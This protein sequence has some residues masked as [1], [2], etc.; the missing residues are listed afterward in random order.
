MI[1]ILNSNSLLNFGINARITVAAD[2][3]SLENGERLLQL[4]VGHGLFLP[5]AMN[6][7]LFVRPSHQVWGHCLGNA[8]GDATPIF[9]IKVTGDGS[10][11]GIVF[12]RSEVLRHE[13][14]C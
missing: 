4:T 11:L 6:L 1:A 5:T 8:T 10:W 12:R 2:F 3:L 7:L 13:R 14:P 9:D